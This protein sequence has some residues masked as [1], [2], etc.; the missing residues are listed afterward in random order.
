MTSSLMSARF[1]GGRR[2]LNFT[3]TQVDTTIAGQTP[4]PSNQNTTGIGTSLNA[5]RFQPGVGGG[6]DDPN[7]AGYSPDMAGTGQA[8]DIGLSPG[9]VARGVTTGIGALIGG[10]PGQVVSAVGRGLS[11]YEQA[12]SYNEILAE[13]GLDQSV[14]PGRSF[15]SAATFGWGGE[16]AQDQFENALQAG[17]ETTRGNALSNLPDPTIATAP[18]AQPL[19]APA[20]YGSDGPGPVGG[21]APDPFAGGNDPYG[22]QDPNNNGPISDPFA[23]GNDP[24]GGSDPNQGSGGGQGGGE[25]TGGGSTSEAGQSSSS[26][27]D[28]GASAGGFYRKGGLIPNDGDGKLEAV[29]VIA[30]EDE[31]V[32]RPEAVKLYGADVM[33]ALNKGLVKPETLRRLFGR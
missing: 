9:D 26:V 31:F 25:T 14:N 17:R 16:K 6:A 23:G 21:P 20:N 32:M 1:R 15:T 8:S 24:Y 29:P 18:P 28:G 5:M 3:P 11:G 33:R 19:D 4:E 10:I 22:G 7:G 2:A 30:H 13:R 27:G 12:K